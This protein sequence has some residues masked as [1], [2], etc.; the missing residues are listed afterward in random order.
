MSQRLVQWTIAKL[1]PEVR[2]CSFF[3]QQ[4]HYLYVPALHS[5][6]EG[7]LEVD[8]LGVWVSPLGGR[9]K[10]HNVTLAMS[11]KVLSIL[12][13]PILHDHHVYLEITTY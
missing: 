13:T 8:V 1:I 11:M 3:H 12:H 5:K 9:G 6:V 4:S 7:G 10:S 2:V